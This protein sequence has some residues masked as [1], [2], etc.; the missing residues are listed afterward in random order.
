MI[1][2]KSPVRISMIGGSLDYPE[3]YLEHG[4]AVITTA[5]NKYVWTIYNNGKI[6][7]SYDVP[8]KSGLA[9]SSAHTVGIMKILAE[10]NSNQPCDSRVIAQFATQVE[11]EKLDGKIGM[12]DQLICSLG[13]FR[14]IRFSEASIRDTTI[15]AKWLEPYLMLF[16]THQYRKRAGD[17]VEAQLN[18]MKSH[19]ELYFKLM[20]LVEQGKLA[21][22][23]KDWQTF[24]SLL[25]E[26]W[27]IKRQ[28]SNKITTEAIDDIYSRGIK[29]GAIGGKILGSGGGGAMLFLAPLDKQEA[30]KNELTECEYIPFKFEPEGT[31]IVF[32]DGN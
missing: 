3:W 28:L 2:S 8:V 29:T 5:I 11:R 1:I 25:G 10:L 23:N 27:Q 17:V 12:Q 4:G 13:G 22:D 31:K 16:I 6:I 30:I 26:S 21:L 24:G 7:D 32:K 9:T 18:E 14:L 15:D 19:T 20:D